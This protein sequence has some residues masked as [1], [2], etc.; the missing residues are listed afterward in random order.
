M[1]KC[2][3]RLLRRT[4]YRQ[5]VVSGVL[6]RGAAVFEE[7][8]DSLTSDRVES[9]LSQ[10]L[11]LSRSSLHQLRSEYDTFKQVTSDSIANKSAEV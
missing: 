10:E 1:S 6:E 5:V 8:V 3:M 9:R 11:A 4:V 7:E 2:S